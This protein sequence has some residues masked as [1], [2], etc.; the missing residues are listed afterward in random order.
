MG[1]KIKPK[2]GVV[3]TGLEGF[4]LETEKLSSFYNT[5][6][7][8]FSNLDLEIYYIEDIIVSEEQIQDA[9]KS[10][11][12]KQI[13]LICLVV[14]VFTPDVLAL[15]I[16]EKLNVPV[17]VLAVSLSI[18][19]LAI[20][21]S[22]LITSTLKKLG[23]SYRFVLGNL[24]KRGTFKDIEFY[25]KA[26]MIRNR[27]KVAR[28][29]LLDYRP[30]IMM[31]LSIDEY[32]ETKVFGSTII[33]LG[34]DD[35]DIYEKSISKKEYEE[36]WG[37]IKRL[38]GLWIIQQCK[39]KWVEDGNKE[40]TWDDIVKL[41]VDSVD[42][43]IFIDVDDPSFE[44]EIFD[45]PA[46]VVNFCNNINKK[47][48]ETI[49]EVSRCIY[50]SLALKYALNIKKLEKI[51]RKKIEL[52]HLVGGGSRNSL[53]CQ[54]ISN[55][56]G[57]PLISGPSETTA[58]GNLLL[59][60]LGNSEIR[61]VNEWREVIINSIELKYYEPED[62]DKWNGKLEIYKKVLAIQ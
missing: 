13:D 12:S 22:Q 7:N 23:Y 10:L 38:V 51:V 5:I 58:M 14:G 6:K 49:G 62:I 30:K 60:M 48:P 19:T 17:V 34:F 47:I 1:K 16:V 8:I 55:A 42:S 53:L 15:R 9:Y 59:Q 40:L 31:N 45:M 32:V 28:I 43:N 29:G 37:R 52:L 57:I 41:T 2:L 56:T 3:L 46:K 27:L 25:A 61:N 24:K 44:K 11:A 33:P 36:E 20:C 4:N 35:F 50:E 54:W 26:S 39:K 21:G 18:N